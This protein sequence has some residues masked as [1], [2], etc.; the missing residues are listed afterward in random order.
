[1]SAAAISIARR[2]RSISRW[3]TS[4]GRSSSSRPTRRPIRTARLIYQSQNRHDDAIPD[5]TAAT[6]YAPNSTDPYLSRGLSYLATGDYK[7]ALDDFNIVVRRD[8]HSYQG[9]TDQGLALEK[10]GERDKAFAAFAHAAAI[11]SELRPGP[12]RHAADGEARRVVPFFLLL[13]RAAGEAGSINGSNVS[14]DR[15]F[16]TEPLATS[17]ENALGCRPA[18]GEVERQEVPRR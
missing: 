1:M 11:N 6:T 2:A 7:A 10:L 4:P 18:I 12:R 14:F 13:S 17:L 9:W 15:V 8:K 5:L 16:F 3:P